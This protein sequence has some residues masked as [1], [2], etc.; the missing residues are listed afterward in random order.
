MKKLILLAIGGAALYQVAKFYKINSV[1]AL[2][3][4]APQLKGLLK[5]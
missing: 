1:D 2:T 5:S 4:L 3:K